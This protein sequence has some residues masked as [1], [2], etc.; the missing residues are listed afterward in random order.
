MN[1]INTQGVPLSL[2]V[3]LA[4]DTYDHNP[5]PFTIS[6]TSLLKPLRQLILGSRA[7]NDDVGVDL[8]GLLSSRMGNAIHDGIERAWLNNYKEAL[9]ALKYPK[10]VV[11]RVV[12]NPT[13]PVTEDQI[14]VY[15]EQRS[16]RQV[17]K[18]TITGK[19]DFVGEGRVE[20]FKSTS[21]F[22]AIHGTKDE[23]YIWQGSIY[24]WLN[25]TL[26]TQDTMAIQWIFTDWSRAK[27]MADKNYPQNRHQEKVFELKSIQETDAFIKRKLELIE[28]FWDAPEDKIPECTLEDLWQSEPTF[29]YYKDPTKTA[30]STK[31]FD[32]KR[33]AYVRLA[34]DGHKGIVKEVPGTVKA[35]RYCPGFSECSQ[36]DRLI[37]EGALVL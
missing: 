31:N 19:F 35:C 7:Q 14:P 17:G 16:S 5:D 26:I 15:L 22:T 12:V 13:E 29:K 20:D 3:F 36:K 30:R 23:D 37:S 1:Y 27:A 6:T 24:R 33:D 11:D 8:L 9:T 10:S 21:V 18:W 4:N 34:E 32:N 2:A 28:R 25:P